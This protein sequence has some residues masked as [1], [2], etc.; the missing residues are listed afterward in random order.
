M[1]SPFC[2]KKLNKEI[3]EFVNRYEPIYKC[4]N[5]DFEIPRFKEIE[6]ELFNKIEKQFLNENYES[7]YLLVVP[8]ILNHNVYIN[9][10]NQ[11][12]IIDDGLTCQE[13]SIIRL[14]RIAMMSKKFHISQISREIETTGDI[15]YWVNK[16][17][18]KIRNYHLIFS[19]VKLREKMIS[20]D[21]LTR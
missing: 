21:N 20:G 14:L 13:K 8:I 5:Q 2:Q 10:F 16:N 9:K 4:N 3:L 12:F 1:I 7:L 17:K 6:I 15:L 19:I 11:D 18:E